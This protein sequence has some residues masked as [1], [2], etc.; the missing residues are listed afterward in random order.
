VIVGCLPAFKSLI[1][2]RAA[3]RRTNQGSSSGGGKSK[4]NSRLRKTSIPLDSFS[5]ERKRANGWHP[6]ATDSQE[7]MVKSDH[8]HAITVKNDIVSTTRLAPSYFYTGERQPIT[9]V[10][11]SNRLS[12]MLRSTVPFLLTKTNQPIFDGRRRLRSRVRF[13]VIGSCRGQFQSRFL[14]D[15]VSGS[16]AMKINF[17]YRGKMFLDCSILLKTAMGLKLSMEAWVWRCTTIGLI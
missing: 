8:A 6:S 13:S 16:L 10:F 11:P 12:H 1:A 3:S 15:V 5:N 14:M 9:D 4:V 7:E 17:S 2:N